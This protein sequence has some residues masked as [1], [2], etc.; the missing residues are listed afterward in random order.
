MA[1]G[2]NAWNGLVAEGA[3]EAGLAYFPRASGPAE[4]ISLSWALEDGNRAF[5]EGIARQAADEEDAALFR[6]LVL[7]EERH[8][9]TLRGLH[10]RIAGEGAT[11]T[12]PAGIEAGGTMEG[13]IPV[14]EALAW[15]RGKAPREIVEFAVAMEANSLDRYIKMGRSVR[16]EQSRGVFLALAAE[17]QAHIQRMA[18]LLDSLQG[19]E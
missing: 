16:D 10:A 17:E 1:G 14:G 7:A 19:R 13:G 6:S 4:M 11:L 5:Y 3:Y 18:S 2:I 15:A 8:K 9:E 12:P